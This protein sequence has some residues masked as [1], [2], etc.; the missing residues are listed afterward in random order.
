M[1]LD[2]IQLIFGP[3]AWNTQRESAPNPLPDPDYSRI[4]VWR[5]S[6]KEFRQSEVSMQEVLDG[7]DH[8]DTRLR[9]EILG[10]LN[11]SGT[12]L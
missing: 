6:T 8:D 4:F 2:D 3:S 9:D 7:L 11:D 12:P 1:A 10:L 5:H